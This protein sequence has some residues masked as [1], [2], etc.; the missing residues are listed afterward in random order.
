MASS[1]EPAGVEPQPA[2][3]TLKVDGAAV[4]GKAPPLWD[5]GSAARLVEFLAGER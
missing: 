4:T 5:G 1:P 3:A 2:F